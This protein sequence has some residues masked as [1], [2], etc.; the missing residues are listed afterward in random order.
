MAKKHK[1]FGIWG[2]G[3]GNNAWNT[4]NNGWQSRN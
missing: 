1:H 2:N 4:N 3:W